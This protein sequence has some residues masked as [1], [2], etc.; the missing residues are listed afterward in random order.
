MRSPAFLSLR[1]LAA[2]LLGLSLCLLPAAAPAATYYSQSSGTPTLLTRWNTVRTG[3]GTSPADFTSGD[4]FTV[5]NGHNLSTTAAWALSGAG[6]GIVVEAGGRLTA[7]NFLI[8]TDHFQL[9]GGAVYF[10][11]V[12]T[13]PNGSASDIPGSSTRTF[14]F[15]SQIQI[16]KWGDGTGLA[17]VPLP[18]GVTWGNLVISVPSLAGHWQQAGALT[19]IGGS[20]VITA[21]GGGTNEFQLVGSGGN[22]TLALGGSFQV[23]SGILNIAAAGGTAAVDLGGINLSGGTFRA[24]GNA[25]LRFVGSSGLVSFS[26]GGTVFDTANIDWT[27]ASGRTLAF[28]GA[29][30][31]LVNPGRTMSVFGNLQFNQGASVTNTGTWTYSG[32]FTNISFAQTSGTITVDAGTVWWPGVSG[33]NFFSLSGGELIFQTPRAIQGIDLRGLIS[34]AQNLSI[35]S[36]CIM[37]TGASFSGSPVF[38]AASTLQYNTPS[39]APGPEW[40]PSGLAPGVLRPAGA[41]QPG[42]LRIL[43]G[44]LTLDA[45]PRCM[46]GSLQLSAG[47]LVLTAGGHFTLGGSWQRLGTSTFTPNDATVWFAGSDNVLHTITGLGLTPEPFARLGFSRSAGSLLLSSPVTLTATSGD[48]LTL[49]GTGDLNLSNKKLTLAGGGQIRVSGG[50]RRITDS[51]G[52]FLAPSA[53]GLTIVAPTTVVSDNGGTL[54]IDT[55]ARLLV[56]SSTLDCGPGLTTIRGYFQ[57]EAAGAVVTN[58]PLY[59]A[60]ST[61][62]YAAGANVRSFEWTAGPGSVAG[63]TPGYPA[64]VKILAGATLDYLAGTPAVARAISGNLTLAANSGALTMANA[65]APLVLGGHLQIDANAGGLTMSA[66][67]ASLV[68]GGNLNLAASSGGLT[69]ANA[70]APLVVGGDVLINAPLQL[71]AASG[72]DLHVGRNWTLNGSAG[73]FQPQGRT[74]RFIGSGAAEIGGDVATAFGQLALAR[75]GGTEI[76]YALTVTRGITAD[77]LEL[78]SGVL[79]VPTSGHF[80]VKGAITGGSSGAFVNG[81]LT[82]EIA[83][84][85]TN[86]PDVL[87]PVGRS[88]FFGLYTPFALVSP[89]TT[90]GAPFPLTVGSFSPPSGVPDPF[91]Y[92]LSSQ[93]YWH[94]DID[95]TGGRLT[96]TAVSLTD[97][98]LFFANRLARLDIPTS[99]TLL[100]ATRVGSALVSAVQDPGTGALGGFLTVAARSVSVV[101]DS[102]PFL[103]STYGQ[104]SAPATVNL[105]VSGLFG[106]LTLTAPDHVELSLDG[107]NWVTGFTAPMQPGGYVTLTVQVR[108]TPLLFPGITLTSVALTSA[109]WDGDYLQCFV[110]VAKALPVLNVT[111]P[112]TFTYNRTAQ[113]PGYFLGPPLP[114]MMAP[115]GKVTLDYTPGATAPTAAGSY[116]LTATVAEDNV[117]L[118][119]T[120]GGYP[121]TIQPAALQ[122]VADGKVKAKGAADPALTYQATGLIAPDGLGGAL[123]RAAGETPG[124]YGIALGTVSAG[125]NYAIAYTPANLVITGPLAGTDSLQK[126]PNVASITIPVATLLANDTRVTNTGA[127][128]TTGLTLTAVTP[129]VGNSVQLQGANVLFTPNPALASD[130][131]TYTLSDGVSED[132]GTV[133]VTNTIVLRLVSVGPASYNAPG[134]TT[135]RA[136]QFQAL[137]DQ[138]VVVEYTVDLQTWTPLNGGVA[139]QAATDGAL[140]ANVSALGNQTVE[141]NQ[142]MHFRG[143]TP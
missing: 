115:K 143:K 17:P 110:D 2:R 77:T 30:I 40:T 41:G 84:G 74:V 108:G 48:V 62:L 8:A 32:T 72:G 54:V 73:H 76:F 78:I 37:N 135:S 24:S 121:F 18:A 102:N 91:G 27:V 112:S 83:G 81:Y 26:G 105:T 44:T 71:S 35:A 60:G 103:S 50:P 111:G 106:D 47:H 120:T 52:S 137:S 124:S 59:D 127:V 5:Q 96:S 1:R 87:F 114:G 14:A 101:Y 122:V 109:D 28:M 133:T 95:H 89:T 36:Y 64:N 86:G 13:S 67:S 132:T 22:L 12:A 70:S 118:G 23:N 53:G 126:A 45:S 119:L 82:R 104:Y 43:S 49:T 130:S 68:V 100:P 139:L 113:S 134:N 38:G 9:N 125:S 85:L 66:A 6:N 136:V 29:N 10:H 39:A 57:R 88:S 21:S 129:G 94:S 51:S 79:D 69:M 107:T 33:P 25:A 16:L 31:P 141:W 80:T 11:D 7:A 93:V 92:F 97:G 142:H 42:G 3:G 140:P 123:T 98:A 58:A 138:A 34:N 65:S 4:T 117:Y 20:L 15:N 61:L 75:T 63:V 128:L 116:V 55:Y 99:A 56:E 19:N 131:F 90:V 46:P